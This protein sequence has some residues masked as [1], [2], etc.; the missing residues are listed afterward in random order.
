MFTGQG[1]MDLAIQSLKNEATDFVTKPID[2]EVLEISIRRAQERIA[3]RRQVREYTENLE[4]LVEEKAARLIE[5]ERMAA[6]GQTIAGLSH[7]IKNIAGGLKGGMFVL[8][9]GI[10]LDEKEFLQQ[11]WT[12][13]K[14]NVD[15]IRELSMDLLNYGK[16]ADIHPSLNDP[17]T[18]A[19]NVVDFFLAQAKDNGIDMQFDPAEKAEAFYF[20]R[21]AIYQ[22]LLNLVSNALDACSDESAPAGD[23]QVLLKASVADGWGI[24]YT[25]SDNG[26]GMSAAVKKDIFQSF[27]STKGTRGTGI[28]LMMTQKIMDQHGGEI[29]VDSTPGAGTT[30]TLKLPLRTSL[31][32][33]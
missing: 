17:N 25:V 3:L 19:R 33:V 10:E 15:K 32:S 28:G 20:D 5:A 2:N 26:I 21:E 14:G 24:V 8:S 12:M 9:K 4:R 23:R 18:P 16:F 1:D 31:D 27:F 6:V 22:C 11:G 30:V 29:A 13:V 7:T